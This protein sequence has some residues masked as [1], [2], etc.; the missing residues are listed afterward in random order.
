[1][2]V[3]ECVVRNGKTV[4]GGSVCTSVLPTVSVIAALFYLYIIGILYNFSLKNSFMVKVIVKTT[5]QL[6]QRLT[7]YTGILGTGS[8]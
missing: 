7:K 1:M 4:E 2:S 8:R 5:G 6:E 3:C